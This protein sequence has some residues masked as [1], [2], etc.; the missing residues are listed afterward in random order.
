[1]AEHHTYFVGARTWDFSVWA[2]NADCDGDGV[3]DTNG[4][5][6]DTHHVFPQAPDLRERFEEVGIKIHDFCVEIDRRFHWEIHPEWNDDW[7]EWLDD[8][9]FAD[10]DEM[11]Q[12]AIEMMEDYGIDWPGEWVQF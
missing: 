4:E 6:T 5:P 1:V 11:F 9:P 3:D 8:N 10:K 2:H 12:K 7:R